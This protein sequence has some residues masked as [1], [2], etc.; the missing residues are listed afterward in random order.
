MPTPNPTSPSQAKVT[1]HSVPRWPCAR[2][3]LCEFAC[4]FLLALA[5]Q[6]SHAAQALNQVSGKALAAGCQHSQGFGAHT[7]PEGSLRFPQG[8]GLHPRCLQTLKPPP[9]LDE[10]DNLGLGTGERM[11]PM[12]PLSLNSPSTKAGP[13]NSA[14]HPPRWRSHLLLLDPS[15]PFQDFHLRGCPVGSV[16][17]GRGSPSFST[18]ETSHRH[19]PSLACHI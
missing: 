4:A 17:A 5:D 12:F 9:T 18:H 2:D 8:P 10:A 14:I 6:S 7:A 19:Y 16:G 3:L 13:P 1:I 15:D 11:D